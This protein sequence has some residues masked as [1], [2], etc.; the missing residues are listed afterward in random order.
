MVETSSGTATAS[1]DS[2]RAPV[3]VVRDLRKRY[4]EI[5][6]VRGISFEIAPGECFGLLGP[7]G[8]GKTTTLQALPRSDRRRRRHHRSRRPH[9]SARRAR[10]RAKWSAWC[11][12]FDNLDPDFTVEENLLDIRALFRD[13]HARISARGFRS[14][15]RSPGSRAAP[16]RG[17]PRCQ[18]A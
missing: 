10:A 14:C 1:A 17:S 15:S 11:P 8:A 9:D 5:D 13:A 3:V 16:N 18:A 7:N 4:G 12:Q 2:V 6:V